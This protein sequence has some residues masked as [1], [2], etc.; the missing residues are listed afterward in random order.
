MRMNKM[1]VRGYASPDEDDDD[2]MTG[3]R[4]RGGA[5]RGRREPARL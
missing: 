2:V 5:Q 4:S 1:P 3:R